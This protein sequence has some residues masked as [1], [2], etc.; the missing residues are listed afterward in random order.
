MGCPTNA[1]Q[2][3]LVSTLPTALDLGAAMLVQTRAARFELQGDKV[4]GLVAEPVALDGAVSG[5]PVRITARHYVVAG[6]AINSPALLLR[7]G[8][9]DPYG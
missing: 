7:S 1:K 6:G 3:M 5:A 8:A 9:P 2:S 4:T